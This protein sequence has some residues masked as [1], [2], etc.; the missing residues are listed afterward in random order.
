MNGKIQRLRF[1]GRPTDVLCLVISQRI[2][3]TFPSRY[4][5]NPS[6]LAAAAQ[7]VF[8]GL[9]TRWTGSDWAGISPDLV[10][11][12]IDSLVTEL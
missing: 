8:D 4:R 1:R 5:G 11:S 2:V 3:K 12:R 7:A 10:E 9:M 6:A